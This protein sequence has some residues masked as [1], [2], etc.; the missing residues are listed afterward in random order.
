MALSQPVLM[1][2]PPPFVQF[3]D[4]CMFIPLD[5]GDKRT[6]WACCMV[7]PELSGVS[8]GAPPADVVRQ[9]APQALRGPNEKEVAA[10]LR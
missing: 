7:L 6:A 5:D 1:R 9:M 10:R 3:G 4:Q 2:P 8:V